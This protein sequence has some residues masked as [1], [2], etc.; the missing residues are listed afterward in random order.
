M[1][2][3]PLARL[4][5][6]DQPVFGLQALPGEEPPDTLAEMAA[7]CASQLS[8]FYPSGPVHLGGYS[9]GAVLAYEVGRQLHAAGRE[10]GLLAVI[11]AICPTVRG[12]RL[13]PTPRGLQRIL[14]NAPRWAVGFAQL[15]PGGMAARARR[16]V[17]GLRRRVSPSADL[18]ALLVSA[19]DH[20]WQHPPAVRQMMALHLRASRAYQPAPYPGRLTLI[21]ARTRPLFEQS[22]PGFGWL[23]LAEGGIEILDTPG[24]H[25]QLLRPPWVAG[26]ARQLGAGLA[27]AQRSDQRSVR[28]GA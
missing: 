15:G 17:Y 3:A 16:K 7:R 21:Q 5:D 18:E 9:F 27:A 10:I 20:A 24:T 1:D 4:L 6:A 12:L 19:I 13:P 25:A 14:A 22:E 2:Y 8:A 28:D 23:E 26:L 11:D